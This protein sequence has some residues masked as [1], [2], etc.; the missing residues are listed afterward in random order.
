ML[1]CGMV[2]RHGGLV[3]LRGQ[4]RWSGANGSTIRAYAE[5]DQRQLH[6]AYHVWTISEHSK[7]ATPQPGTDANDLISCPLCST[8]CIEGGYANLIERCL[9]WVI[10]RGGM[11]RLCQWFLVSVKSRCPKVVRTRAILKSRNSWQWWI[12]WQ[13]KVCLSVLYCTGFFG[14]GA[15]MDLVALIW[16][17]GVKYSTLGEAHILPAICCLLCVAVF[18]YWFSLLLLMF[19][20]L[21]VCRTR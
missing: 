17:W 14:D 6:T 18:L 16:L 7:H 12:P 20:L 3:S 8:T 19:C 9:Q 1:G 5:T 4:D 21:L 10:E 15:L 13:M 11:C 2:V